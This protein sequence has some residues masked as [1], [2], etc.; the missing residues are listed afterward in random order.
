MH[1][2]QSEFQEFEN[3]GN[4]TLSDVDF[5]YNPETGKYDI[6]AIEWDSIYGTYWTKYDS[7]E[8]RDAALESYTNSLN[9]F[10]IRLREAKENERK[11]KIAEAKRI[12]SLKTLGGQF[13]VLKNLTFN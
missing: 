6:P 5:S 13:D 11:V 2:T 12:K 1:I 7:I 4:N 8:A 3:Q 10:V 9:I